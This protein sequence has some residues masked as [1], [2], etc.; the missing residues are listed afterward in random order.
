M[1]PAGLRVVRARPAIMTVCL[2]GFMLVLSCGAGFALVL[3]FR[4]VLVVVFAR[5]A[6]I[7]AMWAVR[8][9]A[10]W[11]ML[12]NIQGSKSKYLLLEITN[13]DGY[14][15]RAQ[16]WDTITYVMPP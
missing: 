3:V 10:M 5:D 15:R 9:M 6:R 1:R 2:P 16:T 13:T 8:M 7:M 4:A 14:T 11:I 12:R